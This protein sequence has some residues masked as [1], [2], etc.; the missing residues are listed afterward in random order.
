M[1]KL[2]EVDETSNFIEISFLY[3]IPGEHEGSAFNLKYYRNNKLVREQR[4]GWTNLILKS[5]LKQLSDFPNVMDNDS[6]EHFEKHF[7]FQWIKEYN[8]NDYMLILSDVGHLHAIK[9]S[10]DAL[11]HFGKQLSK[12]LEDAPQS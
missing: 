6:F 10:S 9:V 11:N 1:A 2:F 3:S 4:V 8:T 7:E 5:L 12:E